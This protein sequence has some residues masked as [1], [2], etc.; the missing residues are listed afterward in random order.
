MPGRNPD[1][2]N[3]E[4]ASPDNTAEATE[5]FLIYFSRLV[6]A[7]SVDFAPMVVVTVIDDD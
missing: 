7:R 5:Q 6:N 2:G 4:T 1:S 3:I